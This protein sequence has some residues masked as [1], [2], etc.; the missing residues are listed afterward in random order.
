MRESI[1]K[2]EI[3]IPETLIHYVIIE[4]AMGWVGIAGNKK[5]LIR[6]ILPERSSENVWQ[7]LNIYFSSQEILVRKDKQFASLTK[8]IRDYFQGKPVEFSQEKINLSNYTPFQRRVLLTARGIPYGE[9]RT[10]R[11][12]AEQSGFPRAYRAVGGVMKINLLPLII[13][14]HRI[15]GS[16][17][18]LTGFSAWGGV[19]LKRGMLALEGILIR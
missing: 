13:P 1:S 16:K 19:E 15:I 14:C 3:N 7:Q 17:G 2:Q 10:Y 5:G 8:L 6:L 18:Q 4:T 11:W 9:T 12:L